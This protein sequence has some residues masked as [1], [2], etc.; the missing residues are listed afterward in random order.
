VTVPVVGPILVFVNNSTRNRIAFELRDEVG[1]RS[2]I[3]SKVIVHYGPG[4]TRHQ[5]RE[6]QAGGGFIS[7][8]APIAYFGLGDFQQVE[9]VEVQW[10]TG[11]RSEIHAAFPAGARYVIHRRSRS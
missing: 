8:E 7:F 5:L 6:I 3:G 4:G 10:S 1:N 11:E 9:R 2:G